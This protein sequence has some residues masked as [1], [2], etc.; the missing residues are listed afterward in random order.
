MFTDDHWMEQALEL[1]RSAEEAGEVPVG[2]L[3][4][5]QDQ[6]IGRGSNSSIAW[7]DPSAHAEVVALREAGR[8]RGNYRLT[9]A[10]V[11]VTLEPCMMCVGAMITAR[12]NRLVFGATDSKAGFLGGAFDARELEFPNHCFEVTAGVCAEQSAA[13]LQDFFRRRRVA[14]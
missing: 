10:V 6:V 2:A 5:C 8:T 7:S 9:D 1:A 11:Y 14:Q 12:I 3:V 4:V 13:L